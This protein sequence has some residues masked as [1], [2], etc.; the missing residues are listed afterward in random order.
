L[1]NLAPALLCA[2]TVG[3]VARSN[4]G[5]FPTTWG[6]AA[7]C[8]LF[9]VAAALILLPAAPLGLLDWAFLGGLAGLM[10]WT[11]LS[12]IWSES[13]PLTALE[14]E[15]SIVYVGGAFALLLVARRESIATALGALL[16]VAVVLCAHALATR[17][18][19]DRITW[20]NSSVGARLA[21]VFGYQNALGIVAALGLLLAAGFVADV[22]ERDDARRGRG[23]RSALDPYALFRKQPRRVDLAPDRPR[24]DGGLH[25]DAPPAARCAG[26]R[27]DHRRIRDLALVPFEATHPLDR[28]GRRRPRRALDGRG[29][30]RPD[31]G[32]S[33]GDAA[34]HAH[35]DARDRGGVRACIRARAVGLARGHSNGGPV[36]RRSHPDR[37]PL[38]HHEQLANGVLARGRARFRPSPGR[39]LGRGD[40][41]PGVVPASNGAGERQGR[42]QQGRGA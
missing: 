28:P 38:Q 41:R 25:A 31:G 34:A 24:R 39:R 4:G 11:A 35:D 1:T 2:G 32:F 23:E 6:W 36:G 18:V 12:W 22:A 7:I 37:A 8:L 10:V 17:F 26:A 33:P 14:I 15:R 21:G 16:A 27:R 30:I 29:D 13:G 3:L 42:A 19:P 20:T 5:W 9:V 40:V